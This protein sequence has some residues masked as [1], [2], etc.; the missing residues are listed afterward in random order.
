MSENKKVEE[1]N[2]PNVWVTILCI[3]LIIAMFFIGWFAGGKTAELEDKTID[4]ATEKEEKKK[5]EKVEK[6]VELVSLRDDLTE[7]VVILEALGDNIYAR[8][9]ENA[10][11]S[12]DSKL[13]NILGKLYRDYYNESPVTTNYNFGNLESNKNYIVQI[14]L[15]RR[16]YE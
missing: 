5:E 3:A 2:T 6:D 9:I 13:Y 4:K 16:Y 11:I 12:N 10:Q 1:K 15:V 14:L 7:K 8:D